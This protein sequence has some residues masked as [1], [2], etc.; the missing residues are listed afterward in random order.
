M[1]LSR[2]GS[3]ANIRECRKDVGKPNQLRESKQRDA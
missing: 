1:D 3:E 2:P